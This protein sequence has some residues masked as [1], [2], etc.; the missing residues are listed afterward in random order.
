MI[1]L[2]DNKSPITKQLETD[3]EENE[4]ATDQEENEHENKN[5]IA[6]NNK[7]QKDKEKQQTFFKIKIVSFVS[8]TILLTISIYVSI[9]ENIKRKKQKL[10]EFNEKVKEGKQS[11]EKSITFYE[12]VIAKTE[13][14]KPPI[15]NPNVFNITNFQEN[16]K[17]IQ[18]NIEA[19]IKAI[20]SILQEI[21]K[22]EKDLQKNQSL[23]NDLINKLNELAE[24][25]NAHD[26][27]AS[28]AFYSIS[29]YLDQQTI[30]E[31]KNFQKELN[32]KPNEQP[33]TS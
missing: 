30:E 23:S 13:S 16:I 31:I 10:N 2:C 17:T 1:L 32:E 3:Q 21:Q 11:C 29:P 20:T 22:L 14:I 25:Y 4:L 9:T 7:H 8:I 28:L 18:A 6:K 19:N 24:N 27:S 26:R 12:F 15:V 5:Q 33:Q